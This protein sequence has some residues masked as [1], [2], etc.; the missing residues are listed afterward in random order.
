PL[1]LLDGDI[2]THSYLFAQLIGDY[3]IIGDL[4]AAFDNFVESGQIYALLIGLFVGYI[5]KSFTSF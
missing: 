3:D 2:S 1:N 5:F 4:K